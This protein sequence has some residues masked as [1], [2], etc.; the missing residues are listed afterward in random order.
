MRMPHGGARLVLVAALV[1]V[2]AAGAGAEPAGALGARPAAVAVTS[3]SAPVAGSTARPATPAAFRP[4]V[5][6]R[7]DAVSRPA[8]FSAATRAAHLRRVTTSVR[9]GR[10]RICTP[11]LT[12]APAADAGRVRHTDPGS[13]PV[14]GVAEH[15]P[16]DTS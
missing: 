10:R 5:A 14:R 13:A 6:A 11:P 9:A 8:A 12:I 3:H 7:A 4:A 15:T 1:A 2:T 16:V